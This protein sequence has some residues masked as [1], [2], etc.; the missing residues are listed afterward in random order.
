MSNVEQAICLEDFETWPS[1]SAMSPFRYPGGKGFLTGYLKSE[2]D[3]LAAGDRHYVEPFAGGAGAAINLLHAG[4]VSHIHLNDLDIRIYSAWRA[5]IE[6]NDRFLDA[7]QKCDVSM[8]TWH[9]SKKLIE[10][11]GDDYSFELGFATFFV[12]RTSRAG[13]ILGSG[14]IGGYA[15]SGIWTINARFYRETILRRLRWIGEKKNR[16]SLTRLPAVNFL[17]A[18]SED[19]P[20][21]RTLYFIDPPYVKIG[22]RLYLDGMIDGAHKDLADFI[23]LDKLR[24]WVITYDNH[25]LIRKLYQDSLMRLLKV[26]YSLGRSRKESEVLISSASLH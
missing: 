13:I 21:E 14:P 16:I 6:E 15:Q 24:F 25:D 26:N 23:K 9:Q 4:C 2:V 12:N 18:C 3:K 8:E 11:P 19:L 7:V 1:K 17:K 20:A 22:S 10:K 5:I